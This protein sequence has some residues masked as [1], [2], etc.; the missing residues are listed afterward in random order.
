[1]H[2]VNPDHGTDHRPDRRIS[3]A[4]NASTVLLISLVT[5]VTSFVNRTVFVRCLPTEYI[6]LGGLLGNLLGLLSL[7]EL[8]IGLCDE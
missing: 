3:S 8:G 1:M 5:L 7:A 4:R 6:G 2:S